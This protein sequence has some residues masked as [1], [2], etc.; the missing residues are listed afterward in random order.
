[1]L[2]EKPIY[3]IAS[4]GRIIRVC[5][6]AKH[7]CMSEVLLSTAGCR[8]QVHVPKAGG[9]GCKEMETGGEVKCQRLVPLTL[10]QQSVIHETAPFSLPPPLYGGY[11][12]YQCKQTSLHLLGCAA[13]H[14]WALGICG[15][16][17]HSDAPTLSLGQGLK[18]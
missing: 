7:N 5:V 8:T 3:V 1:M 17:P 14:R 15:L 12:V 16:L 4:E 13:D 18:T 9:L 10:L 2:I 11:I 6:L